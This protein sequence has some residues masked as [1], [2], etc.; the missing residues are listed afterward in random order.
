M[1]AGILTLQEADN[2][3]AVLQAYALQTAL[4]Y[5][6]V[7][8]E[9]IIF[10]EDVLSEKAGQNEADNSKAFLRHLRENA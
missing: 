10:E 1:K 7:E 3:G 5:L 2:Y 4:T 9:F 6:D 8:S